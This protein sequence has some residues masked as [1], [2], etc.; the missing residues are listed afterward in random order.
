M[1]RFL[2]AAVAAVMPVAAVANV[3]HV[4]VDQDLAVHVAYGDL[5]LS[6]QE[7]RD[8][9]ISR[10]NFAAKH[11][12]GAEDFNYPYRSSRKCYRVA[13]AGG[14]EQM[15]AIRPDRRR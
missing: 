1:T 8:T 15:Q 6:S 13:L 11:A 2:I 9:L 7:G 4:A 14:I 10:I 12:C 5:D 3:T